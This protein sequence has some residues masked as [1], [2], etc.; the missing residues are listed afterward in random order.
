MLQYMDNHDTVLVCG[1]EK[2]PCHNLLLELYSHCPVFL[3]GLLKAR[4]TKEQLLIEVDIV[5][6]D[7]LKKLVEFMYKGKA[8]I[9]KQY[10]L[11]CFEFA[12]KYQMPI[13]NRVCERALMDC[14][15][16][17]N[18]GVFAAIA[19]KYSCKHNVLECEHA[20]VTAMLRL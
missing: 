13:L 15:N 10:L 20:A 6:P 11:S 19:R 9:P 7:V 8:K 3:E 14:L 16:G 2:I 18:A 4:C 5:K 1:D 12:K 17:A